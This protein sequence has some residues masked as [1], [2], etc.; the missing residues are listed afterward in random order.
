MLK[1]TRCGVFQAKESVK[2]WVSEA[3]ATKAAKK[4]SHVKDNS[5]F[6]VVYYPQRDSYA[7][8]VSEAWAKHDGIWEPFEIVARYSKKHWYSNW[9]CEQPASSENKLKTRR[10]YTS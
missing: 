7:Y 9:K 8:F 5:S 3:L 10:G 4:S 6:I 1:N 2:M